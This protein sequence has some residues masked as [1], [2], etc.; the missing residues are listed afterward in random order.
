MNKRDIFDFIT[1]HNMAVQASLLPSGAPQAAAIGFVATEEL[2]LF[3][4]TLGSSRKAQ[5]LR[6]DPRLAVVIGWDDA[7]GRTVQYEGL[8]DEPKGPELDRLKALYLARFPDGR[9]RERWPAITYFRV[10]PTWIRFSDYGGAAPRIV[11]LGVAEL[12]RPAAP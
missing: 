11:E 9:E 4:D 2:E 12:S 6:R 10:R 1:R 7:D 5:N 8:A 3:F